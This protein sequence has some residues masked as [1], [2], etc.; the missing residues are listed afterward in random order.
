MASTDV[1]DLD[2]EDSYSDLFDDEDSDSFCI[3]DFMDP[4]LYRELFLEGDGI[5]SSPDSEEVT[6]PGLTRWMRELK[7]GVLP[8]PVPLKLQCLMFVIGHLFQP[9][10]SVP[11]SM[12][13]LL[14]RS[15]RIK[16]LL[17]LPAIDICKLESTSVTHGIV[18]DEIWKALFKER[19]PA[20]FLEKL[21]PQL[22]QSIVFDTPDKFKEKFDILITWKEAYFD[23]VFFLSQEKL[24]HDFECHCNSDHFIQ[25]LL[26]G[27]GGIHKGT[28][29]ITD[30]FK[31][32]DT[33]SIHGIYCCT[34]TCIRLTTANHYHKF[35][36]LLAPEP[37][38]SVCHDN[39]FTSDI[40]NELIDCGVFLRKLTLSD[41]YLSAIERYLKNPGFIKK[42][43][44]L[45]HSVEVL[46]V[47]EF[48][49][50]NA[51]KSSFN[52]ILNLVFPP[53][54]PSVVKSVT[55]LN[56]FEVVG[57]HLKGHNLK[58]LGISFCLNHST[59]FRTQWVKKGQIVP[60]R[61][62]LNI[63][64]KITEII[65]TQKELESFTF[66]L[67]T[68]DSRKCRLLDNDLIR[69]LYNVLQLSSLRKF[70]F[71]ASH[72]HSQV[73]SVILCN[74]LSLFLSS[75]YP[76][77]LTLSLSCPLL[78]QQPKPLTANPAPLK[79]LEIN[80]CT[81]PPNLPSFLPQNLVLKSLKLQDNKWS[82]VSLFTNLQ[83]ITVEELVLHT[84][85]KM[86]NDD[87]KTFLLLFSIVTAREWKLGLNIE[88]K[89]GTLETLLHVLTM[90]TCKSN[91]HSFHFLRDE[92]FAL[93]P[94][95]GDTIV[96]IMKT[97]FDS[98]SPSKPSYFDF[99]ISENQLQVLLKDIER[100]WEE[101]SKIKMKTIRV[102]GIQSFDHD[103]YRSVL[104]DMTEELDLCDALKVE[105]RDD[106]SLL[107]Y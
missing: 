55:L 97:I 44:K 84:S 6:R 19:I 5:E 89:P 18:M 2:E 13:A 65:N 29:E 47:S 68:D 92:E 21:E 43:N 79:T 54:Q 33:L 51:N 58:H 7:P 28:M 102:F 101:S 66:T 77:S 10:H 70:K 53:R 48:D 76:L 32:G 45:F 91:L 59:V 88:D 94:V 96:S 80:D 27:I 74:L 100:L 62:R 61:I 49:T 86:T 40:V 42:L 17:L 104:E 71:D 60:V 38:F 82:T 9:D 105:S 103:Y 87:V 4:L 106:Y 8:Y 78:D 83:S 37:L 11:V 15:I 98:L 81:F 31:E 73:S 26:Y 20:F 63:S 57:P 95:K 36:D 1:E 23:T 56:E 34:M 107:Y 35:G 25:D 16:L 12:I 85:E 64:R 69:C 67:I 50:S 93:P 22:A 24:N 90:I 52:K 46:T 99:A 30:C 72:L 41:R 39:R 75:P 14:P 3:Q